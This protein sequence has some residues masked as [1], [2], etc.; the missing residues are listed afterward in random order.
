MT[1]ARSR[2][3]QAV[4]SWAKDAP[5]TAVVNRDVLETDAAAVGRRL[6]RIRANNG[7][8]LTPP[9]VLEDARNPRSPLHSAFDWSDGEAAEKWRLHQARHLIIVVRVTYEESPEAPPIRAFVSITKPTGG[10]TYMPT[11]EALSDADIKQSVLDSVLSELTRIR[12]KYAA[13]SELAD[14]F[15][16]IDT[17]VEARRAPAPRTRAAAPE[18]HASI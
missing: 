6:D 14:V 10:R 11:R 4:Y 1:R 13:L 9:M 8:D 12:Q 7:G 3:R 15:A 18:Q 5:S 2:A 17:V 16:A